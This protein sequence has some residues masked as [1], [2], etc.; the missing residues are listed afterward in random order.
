MYLRML[1]I[2]FE[3]Y[4]IHLDERTARSKFRFFWLGDG[5]VMILHRCSMSK[6]VQCA[7]WDEPWQRRVASQADSLLCWWTN[8]DTKFCSIGMDVQWSSQKQKW[9]HMVQ[10]NGCALWLLHLDTTVIGEVVIVG[11][12]DSDKN[13]LS[14]RLGV[15][16]SEWEGV[17]SL[18]G[19]KI[20]VEAWTCDTIWTLHYVY[21]VVWYCTTVLAVPKPK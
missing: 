11:P 16:I 19:I 8:V 2:T 5:H 9:Y 3:W 12:L 13:R 10:Q 4:L 7:R 15:G 20:A 14:C 6:D 21:N 17:M 1:T 18:H